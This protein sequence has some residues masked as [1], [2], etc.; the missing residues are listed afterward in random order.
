MQRRKKKTLVTALA[1]ALLGAGLIL[2][3]IGAQAHHLADAGVAMSGVK[4][5]EGGGIHTC[6]LTDA[7]AVWC[8]GGN[9]TGQL[10]DGLVGTARPFPRPVNGMRGVTAVSLALGTD[11]S[12]ALTDAGAVWCWG[13]NLSGQIGRSGNLSVAQTVPVALD[14][15]DGSGAPVTFTSITAGNAHTCAVSTGGVAW[16]WGADDKGQLGRNNAS[17]GSSAPA[18]VHSGDMGTVRSISAGGDHTCAISSNGRV[19]CWGNNEDG[20]LGVGDHLTRR[21]PVAVVETNGF[22]GGGVTQVEA[23]DF[24][25]CAATTPGSVFC[26]G[27]NTFGRIGNPAGTS[28]KLPTKVQGHPGIV[29]HGNAV[30]FKADRVS[31]GVEHSCAWRE[32]D[33]MAWCW[34]RGLF[35]QLGDGAPTSTVMLPRARVKGETVL[36][37]PTGAIEALS[38]GSNHVCTINTG[39]MAFCWGM[40]LL[41][42]LGETTFVNHAQPAMVLQPT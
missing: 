42:Q 29:Q 26:W 22:P 7:G 34:G 13:G 24:H 36:L 12:C 8:W 33:G 16:C 10:G 14:I 15:R 23:S 25:T 20:R 21:K 35:G 18:P 3:P 30:D 6:A 5:V 37:E 17:D 9:A 27:S 40:N 32:S 38:S 41:G 2:A 11:H 4:A 31:L 39:G 28:A 19:W 1:A